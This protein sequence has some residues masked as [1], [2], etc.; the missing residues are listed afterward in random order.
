MPEKITHPRRWTGL[1]LDPFEDLIL[2]EFVRGSSLRS[3]RNRL[4]KQ[5]CTASISTISAFIQSR[6][7]ARIRTSYEQTKVQSTGTA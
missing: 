4:G 2:I 7:D 1:K 6:P 5:K 3:I